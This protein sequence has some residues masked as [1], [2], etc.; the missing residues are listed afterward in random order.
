MQ[1]SYV[2]HER[3][4]SALC[5]QHCLNNLLQGSYF[6]PG[7][8][9]D[10][11]QE[12]DA[13]E[14]QMMLEAG[15]DTPEAI[16]FL[17]EESGNVDNSG[18]F[19][20]QVLNKAVER[21]HGVSL[22][23]SDS[24]EHRA[25]ANAQGLLD[26]EAFV[27]NRAAH[28]F[29]IRKLHGEYYNLNSTLDKPEKISDFYLDA[30]L[31]QLRDEGY[32]VFIAAPIA[33]LPAPPVG[34]GGMG[35]G[36]FGNP[37]Y[38]WRTVDLVR[39]IGGGTEGTTAKPTTESNVPVD[40]W[41]AAGAGHSLVD[42]PPTSQ[43]DVGFGAAMA[44]DEEEQLRAAIAA[45]VGGDLGGGGGNDYDIGGTS[46]TGGE[47]DEE[48]DDELRRAIAMSMQ[49]AGDDGGGGG[50]GGSGGASAGAIP[51]ASV[52]STAVTSAS[53]GAAIDALSLPDEPGEGEQGIVRIQLR[54]GSPDVGGKR[55]SVRSFRPSEPAAL[56]FV[57]ANAELEGTA[58]QGRT[59]EL[60]FNM[61]PLKREE[62]GGKDFLAAG[63]SPSA[64]LSMRFK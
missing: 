49:D 12:L 20:I 6:S 29:T 61:R 59:F 44:M 35:E 17:A 52:P 41:A 11:A 3:Q 62:F 23:N 48:D 55:S 47:A 7:D 57:W 37:T 27:C 13:M 8:L 60:I 24:E 56:V 46:A 58:A 28:W 63:L 2:Y 9:A 51:S 36:G 45:S 34:S 53:T 42:P 22:I 26:Q 38:F 15:V 32:T 50:S 10:I 16:A 18:N 25:G 40:P 21:S 14:R 33:N 30:F 54:F 5:G 64:A 1:A 19:S 43:T 31:R 4:E 39:G